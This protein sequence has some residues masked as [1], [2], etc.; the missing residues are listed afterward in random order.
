MKHFVK[1]PYLAIGWLWFLGTFIPVIG[2]IKIGSHAMADRYTYITF[3]GLYVMIAW[4]VP[5][6]LNQFRYKKIVL[7]S[8]AVAL[9]VALMI[10]AKNQTSYWANSIRL[11]NHSIEVSQNNFLAHRNLGLA[12]SYRGQL[13]EAIEHFKQALRINPKSAKCYNDIGAYLM[14]KG[15]YDDSIG[16]FKKALSFQPN[17]PKA[18]NNLGLVL[19]AKKNYAE[20]ASHFQEALR[21]DPDFK[22]ARKNLQKAIATVKHK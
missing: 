2:I 9:I 10:T 15:K 14:L 1:H 17:F 12:L 18:H 3:I 7:A 11:F 5:G 20:A 19:M 6:I 21:A 22:P 16:Y 4:G 8:A 13:D